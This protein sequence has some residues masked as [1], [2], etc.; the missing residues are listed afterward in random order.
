[1]MHENLGLVTVRQVAEGV[2]N[3]TFVTDNIINYRVTISAKGGAYHFPLYLYQKKDN[4]KKRSSGGI[5]M[6]FEPQ[7]EYGVKKPNISPAI[8]EQLTKD[9]K[10]TPSPEQIFFYIYA[11]LYSN[12]YRTKYAEFLK[13]DFPRIP[14]TKDY[15]LFI[16][17]AEY[18]KRL[19][20][21]HLL[22]S[23][24]IDK[25]AAR[26]QG[27]GNFKVEK[28]RYD[29]NRLYINQ[30]QH[31]EGISKEVYQYQIG[32]YQVCD[33]WLKDRKGKS[34]SLDDIKHYCNIVTSIQKTIEIQKGIDESYGKIE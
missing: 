2:F 13:I 31:F 23:T 15:K 26:L 8:V 32:G 29:E 24:E 30:S 14:F 19:V 17:M 12:I 6:L 7:A 5:M 28:L 18:G 1:M 3:H 33:K 22:K 21:L 20:D 11:V 4:P 25:P 16:K 10:K 9:Y 27:K 34:L